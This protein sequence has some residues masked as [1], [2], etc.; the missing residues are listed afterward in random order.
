LLHCAVTGVS[1][2]NA[3]G[4]ESAA[5]QHLKA[6]RRREQ[7]DFVTANFREHPF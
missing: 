5:G 1:M 3:S 7:R 2:L 6:D 4:G